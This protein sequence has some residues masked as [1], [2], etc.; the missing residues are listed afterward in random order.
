VGKWLR[1]KTSFH[2]SKFRGGRNDAAWKRPGAANTGAEYTTNP[3]DKAGTDAH[4]R[5]AE[6]YDSEDGYGG[7]AENPGPA[8]AENAEGQD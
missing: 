7:Q 4:C 6:G 3:R 2:R 5:R 8:Y 1:A